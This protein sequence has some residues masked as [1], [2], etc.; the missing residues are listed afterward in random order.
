MARRFLVAALLLVPAVGAH[1]ACTTPEARQTVQVRYAQA[2]AA[3]RQNDPT[4]FEAQD[5][6]RLKDAATAKRSGELKECQF[7]E[8]YIKL[9]HKPAETAVPGGGVQ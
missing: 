3:W 6:Q 9:S 5:E 1:A 8:K 4:G 7:R 2:M